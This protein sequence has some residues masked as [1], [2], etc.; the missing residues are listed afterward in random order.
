MR[1]SKFLDQTEF[2]GNWKIL[3]GKC[4]KILYTKGSDKM[5]YAKSADSD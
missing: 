3:Y 4:P 1:S 2:I 5:A